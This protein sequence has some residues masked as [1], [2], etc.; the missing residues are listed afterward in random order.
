MKRN[1]ILIVGLFI[2]YSGVF[3]QGVRF[4]ITVDPQINWMKSDVKTVTSEGS[5]LGMNIGLV[6]DKYFTK[7]YAI[8]SGITINN[9]GGKLKY[10]Q[11]E[12]LKGSSGTITVPANTV[13]EYGLQ[14]VSIPLGLKLHTNE[15]GYMKY[16]A[17]LGF[18]GHV[19]IKSKFDSEEASLDDLSTDG[20]SNESISE[21]VSLFNAGYFIGGGAQY[22]LGGNAAIFI[23]VN[24]HQGLMD[25]IKEEVSDNKTV[26]GTVSVRLGIMF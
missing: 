22:S 6:M 8:T 20:V 19:N 14:Y 13:V 12:E 21:S 7:N 5:K 4:G 9:L 10:G 17:E 3:G 1:I 15:I 2:L 24:Y 23:G 11:D 16:Y 25:V 18:N 26:L